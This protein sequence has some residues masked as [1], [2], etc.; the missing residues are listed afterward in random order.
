MTQIS[1]SQLH[2]EAVQIATW[3]APPPQ[4][5]AASSSKVTSLDAASQ[6]QVVGNVAVGDGSALPDLGP[7]SSFGSWE[8]VASTLL[9]KTAAVSGF[10]PGSPNFDPVAW[11]NFLVKFSTIPFLLS[12]TSTTRHASFSSLT[13]NQVT[14]A[15]SDLIQPFVTPE[16]FNSVVTTL[17][18][19]AALAVQ[20]KGQTE[21]DSNQQLG[22]LSRKS[23]QLYLGIVRTSVEMQY[24]SSKGGY[25][26]LQQDLSIY[27]GYGVLSFDKC[28]RTASTLLAW[29]PQ[30]VN[31]WV[32]S[33]DSDSVSPNGSP[34]WNS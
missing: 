22:I 12:Y 18:K 7:L 11:H 1:K 2:R 25:E 4:L 6:E 32:S 26:P 9:F 21:K 29:G 17:K 14:A 8:N 3:M 5:E 28:K 27:C 30:D 13:L 20:N 34:A 24:K 16:N 31:A 10:N 19:M 33:T 23:G 15:V